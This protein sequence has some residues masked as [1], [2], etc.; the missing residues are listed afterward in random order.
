MTPDDFRRIALSMLE[1]TEGSH[2]GH[3]DFRVGGKIFATLPGGGFGVVK[4]G[5]DEQALLVESEPAMFEPVPGGWGRRGSTR[6]KL[7][8]ADETTV[9]SAITTA[10]RRVSAKSPAR[11][12]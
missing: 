6:V 8:A 11:R 5:P 9:R 10:W 2:M 4:I 1:A 12:K 7:Q 3:A